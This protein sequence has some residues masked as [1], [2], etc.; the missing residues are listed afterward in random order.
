M[1]KK[2]TKAVSQRQTIRP[3]DSLGYR[4]WQ[5]HHSWQRFLGQ[6]LSELD[7]THLQFILLSTTQFLCRQQEVP[8]QRQLANFLRL[9]QMMVSKAL[10][11]L[12]G[13]NY[14]VR[15][16]HPKDPRA[17]GLELTCA[18]EEV[19]TKALAIAVRAHA[20]FF[21]VLDGGERMLADS[22]QALLDRHRPE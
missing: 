3:P 12:E 6:C 14:I 19:V 17:I 18:G 9:D 16:T 10:R 8:S 15:K 7:L 21:G 4:L 2:E 11:L 1:K 22:L 13:K 20:S 5:V